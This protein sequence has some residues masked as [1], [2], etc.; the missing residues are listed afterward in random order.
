V[1]KLVY[2]LWRKPDEDADG[3]AAR[4]L[5]ELPTELAAAGAR[6]V[7][8]NIADNAV[9][10]AM[11][12]LSTFDAA[13]SAVVGLWVDRSADAVRMP[14]EAI[15]ARVCARV[16]GWLVTESVPLDPALPTGPERQRGLA[17]IA[18][19]RRP[20][21]MPY[22]RWLAAWQNQHTQVAIE[23]QS[24]FGY[25]QNAVVR[26]VT[27]DAPRVDGIV[28]ELFPI[29]AL[30]DPHAFYDSAGDGVALAQ[31]VTRMVDS[32]RRFGA[33]QDLDVIPTSRY[34]LSTPFA[35][36]DAQTEARGRLF[37][38]ELAE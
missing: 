36:P 30:K 10:D 2:L 34:V 8:L 1:E 29:E 25:V 12:K 3:F 37:M 24:T 23:T 35:P 11:L 5:S 38:H 31:R 32:V 13:V 27:S 20:P 17:Q 21:D 9:A 16:E 19:I 6:G 7:Q 14:L 33:D 28:E 15:L 22:D 4:L 18:L 26:P